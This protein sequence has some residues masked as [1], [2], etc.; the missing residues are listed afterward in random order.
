MDQVLA[1]LKKYRLILILGVITFAASFYI[2][3]K[4]DPEVKAYSEKLVKLHQK[5]EVIFLDF[6]DFVSKVD[7]ATN[8]E[9]FSEEQQDKI[10]AY[11]EKLESN[12]EK[13]EAIYDNE[14]DNQDNPLLISN[15]RTVPSSELEDKS[16]LLLAGIDK[17]LNL[18]NE[19]EKEMPE[20]VKEEYDATPVQNLQ[21]VLNET[22]VDGVGF[23]KTIRILLIF[24]LAIIFAGIFIFLE[25]KVENKKV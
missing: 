3:L 6:S 2:A 9:E 11:K 19:I 18:A 17:V 15:P 16:R 22:S 12:I 4:I 10:K 5:T 20:E 13:I 24:G 25:K 23:K 21:N 1:F 14:I 7:D 8:S